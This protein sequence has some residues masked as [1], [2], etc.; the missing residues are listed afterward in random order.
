MSVAR[1]G[2]TSLWWRG[3]M[4]THQRVLL[5]DAGDPQGTPGIPSGILTS[6][7]GHDSERPPDRRFPPLALTLVI[8]PGGRPPGRRSSE[9]ETAS[10]GDRERC[11]DG[12]TGRTT[13]RRS[14]RRIQQGRSTQTGRANEPLEPA[15]E[16]PKQSGEIAPS[17]CPFRRSRADALRGETQIPRSLATEVS[18]VDPARPDGAG[19][20]E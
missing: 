14:T 6:G 1:L 2:R 20:G 19:N 12:L 3:L 9:I 4:D 10:D 13:A 15:P 11:Y 8:A 18:D 17:S 16:P 5:V 7:G